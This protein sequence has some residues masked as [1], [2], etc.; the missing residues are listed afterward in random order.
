MWAREFERYAAYSLASQTSLKLTP[1]SLEKQGS[2]STI[3][4]V[5]GATGSG[6]SSILNAMLDGKHPPFLTFFRH[7]GYSLTLPIFFRQYRAYERN[8]R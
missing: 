5:C 8:A 2:P 1:I 7:L 3:I 6:K 4:A